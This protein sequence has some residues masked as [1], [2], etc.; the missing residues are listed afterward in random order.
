[1]AKVFEVIVCF[2]DMKKFIQ[3]IHFFEVVIALQTFRSSSSTFTFT[4]LYN[5]FLDMQKFYFS[6]LVLA[7]V[8]SM[9]EALPLQY[10]SQLNQ[11]FVS[12]LLRMVE[13]PPD[14]DEEMK[15]LLLYSFNLIA[16]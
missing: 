13:N 5:C 10:Y 2:V 7:M 4:T 9:G 8:F 3:Y 16:Q 14:S 6:A 1:M 15:V 11:E 12:G